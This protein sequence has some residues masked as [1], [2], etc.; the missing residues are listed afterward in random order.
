MDN[1]EKT[2]GHPSGRK[3][4]LTALQKSEEWSRA[5]LQADIAVHNESEDALRQ[6]ALDLRALTLRLQ[7]VREEERAVLS[8]ELHDNLGQ[9][10]TA[11]ALQFE[12]LSMDSRKLAANISDCTALHEMIVAMAPLL[13]RMTGQAQKMCVSLNSVVLC[14]LGLPDAIEWQVED[15]AKR[16]GL[17]FT[18]ALP[19]DE[20]VFDRELTRALFRILQEALTNVV[21]HAQA[22][23]VDV[24]LTSGGDGLLLEIRDNGCGF[25]VKP[26]FGAQA[27]GLLGMRER[28]GMFGGTLEILSEPGK[29]TTVRVRMPGDHALARPDVGDSK[30]HGDGC[31]R[32]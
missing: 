23:R 10:M 3:L 5:I 19:E 27:F 15:T 29:G 1:D 32:R 6:T 9:L 31:Q 20:V 7:S 12:L 17:I 8:R 21:R 2:A 14:D 24:R 25:V 4:L 13:E 26:H 22:K 16:A 18:I 28:A 11:F 30:Q